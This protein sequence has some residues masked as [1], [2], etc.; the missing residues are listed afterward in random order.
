MKT[1]T[2][3]IVAY[4][5]TANRVIY[6]GGDSAGV[7]GYHISARKDTKVFKNGEMLM[8]Y[9]S[10]FRMGQ[11]LRFKLKVPPQLSIKTDYE[12]MVTDFIDAIKE[13]YKENGY[14]EIEEN[15]NATGGQFLVGYKGN[16][17]EIEDDF[18]VGMVDVSYMSCGCGSDIARGSYLILELDEEFEEC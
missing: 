1:T 18:Q 3:C 15:K 16:L 4:N 9:T 11:L 12:F 5:D 8:G 7:A 17:Y 6:M 13:C 14:G 10:S 2:T